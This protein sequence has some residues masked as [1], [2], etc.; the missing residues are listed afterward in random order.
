MKIPL[1]IAQGKITVLATILHKRIFGHIEF[2]IDTGSDTSFIGYS[3]ALKLKIPIS[4]LQFSHHAKIGG[5]SIELKKIDNVNFIF[6][7]E[8]KEG[9]KICEPLFLV[10]NNVRKQDEIAQAFPSILGLNFLLEHRFALHVNPYKNEAYLEEE[11]S[12]GQTSDSV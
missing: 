2:F 1:T 10:A 8:Q 6:R 5:G 11:N 4:A 9:E 12:Q 3:D 7:N